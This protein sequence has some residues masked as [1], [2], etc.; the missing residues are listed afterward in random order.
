[1]KHVKRI[2]AGVGA[3]TA[4]AFS[5]GVVSS[6]CVEAE[7]QFYITMPMKVKV[8]ED[9]VGCETGD[10]AGC[11]G[12]GISPGTQYGCFLV[13]S[14]LIPRA[15]NDTNRPET[16]LIIFNQVDL[17]LFDSS[18]AVVDSFSA[19]AN[20]VLAPADPE[21]GSS[22]VASLP[23]ARTEGISQIAP[24]TNFVV[25]VILKGRTTGG[26]DIETP[27]YFLAGV[28][29]QGTCPVDSSCCSTI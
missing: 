1:M 5:L 6:G 13:H 24:G 26:L 3:C 17:E 9:G 12:L 19:P 18:G 8:S 25:G 29:S 23:V 16:N 15:K 22:I 20:G 27:E 11:A 4:L 21:S 2:L 28:A 10:D 7:A 14:G